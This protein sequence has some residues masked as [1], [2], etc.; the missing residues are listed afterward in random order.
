MEHSQEIESLRRRI[1]AHGDA[2]NRM[3]IER[4]LMLHKAERKRIAEADI[5]KK[6]YAKILSD[7]RSMILPNDGAGATETDDD[8]TAQMLFD[9]SCGGGQQ[10]A[11]DDNGNTADDKTA[12]MLFDASADDGEQP[13]NSSNNATDDEDEKIAESIFNGSA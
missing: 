4:P 2:I 11:P 1:F 13:E 8:R 3:I 5:D 10:V 6:V 7:R 12:Q 9:V